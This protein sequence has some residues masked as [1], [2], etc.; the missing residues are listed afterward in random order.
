MKC[1]EISFQ[2]LM[3]YFKCENKFKR[4]MGSNRGK[5]VIIDNEAL[6]PPFSPIITCCKDAKR[7]SAS[8][9]MGPKRLVSPGSS[10]VFTE[11]PSPKAVELG[12]VGELL[13][14]VTSVTGTKIGVL[15]PNAGAITWIVGDLL[16]P[17]PLIRGLLFPSVGLVIGK[18]FLYGGRRN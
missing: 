17:P 18:G 11:L 8:R 3:F 14:S 10:K 4:E 1:S 12:V 6:Y 2:C 7:S 13:T 16:M 15:T 5:L 9:S